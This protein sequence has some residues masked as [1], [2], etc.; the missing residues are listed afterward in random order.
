MSLKRRIEESR[1]RDELD[2]VGSSA[3][4]DRS[5]SGVDEASETK[6]RQ[7]RVRFDKQIVFHFP[8]TQGYICVPSNGGSTL[9]LKERHSFV[10]H[11][12]IPP[13]VPSECSSD[14]EDDEEEDSCGDNSECD[15]DTDS[16]DAGG[17]MPISQK[18]RKAILKAAGVKKI[19]RQEATEC[20]QIRFSRQICGCEC[21]ERCDPNSCVCSLNGINCQVDRDNFPCGCSRV[22]CGNPNGRHEYDPI[23]VRRHFVDTVLR[24]Q[25]QNYIWGGTAVPLQE[26]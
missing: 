24:L 5:D 11:V 14:S 1:D 2:S 8:R 26:N 7:R 20:M 13:Y 22:G 21:K 25:G 16:Y 3:S 9:G 23:S 4:G 18:R 17:F 6:K 19:N 12:D 10:E 15:D